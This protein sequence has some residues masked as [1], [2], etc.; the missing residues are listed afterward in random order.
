VNRVSIPCKSLTFSLS[1]PESGLKISIKNGPRLA[2]ERAVVPSSAGKLTFRQGLQMAD[3]GATSIS[4]RVAVA[5]GLCTA[6]A[7]S[8]RLSN[9]HS[10]NRRRG[11]GTLDLLWRI[12]KATIGTPS[13]FHNRSSARRR[14]DEHVWV[15][16]TT[17]LIN[18]CLSRYWIAVGIP[19]SV[20]PPARSRTGAY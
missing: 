4:R 13:C 20:V 2:D 9:I 18:V 12:S 10:L 1:P 15:L 8:I 5:R 6:F 11:F 3:L 19:L 16:R 7:G 17:Q 14:I